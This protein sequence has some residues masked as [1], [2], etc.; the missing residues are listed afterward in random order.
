MFFLFL[1]LF[2]CLL[3]FLLFVCFLFVV[4]VVCL[5]LSNDVTRRVTHT[6]FLTAYRQGIDV[7]R[8]VESEDIETNRPLQW[9]IKTNNR[10]VIE[11]LFR[12]GTSSNTRKWNLQTPLHLAAACGN[13]DLVELLIDREALVN[14][15]DSD[16]VT[17]LHW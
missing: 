15:K 11:L 7:K 14:C 10:A 13:T 8:H 12:H 4:V 3:L 5:L 1:L 2:V 16:R 17:P 6:L 9:A